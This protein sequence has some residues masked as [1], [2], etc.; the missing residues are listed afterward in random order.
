MSLETRLIAL[1]QAIGADIKT[2]TTNQGIL[3]NLT[4]TTKVN[5][6]AAIN[7]LV[8]E[9]GDLSSLN[10]TA[11][12]NLVAALNEVLLELGDVT[13]L[14]TSTKV[15][16]VA[17]INEL[18]LAVDALASSGAGSYTNVTPTPTAL[19]GIASGST[20]SAVTW[21]GMFDSLLYPY[22]SPTFSSFAFTGQSTPLE[23]GDSVASNRTFTWATTN[24]ANVTVNSV[25][26]ETP[27]GTPVATG[28]ANDGTEAVT[29]G[30]ITLNTPGTRVFRVK[31]TN[32]N[33]VVFT[34]DN[35]I[36]WRWKRFS[37]NSSTIG[38]LVEAEVEALST[39]ALV[40]SGAA[41]YTFA[42]AAGTYKYIAYP[43]SF[44]TLAI[45]KDQSTNLDVP[46]QALYVVSLTNAFGQ[47]TN[48]NV[49]R[50]TNQLGAAINIVAS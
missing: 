28:L 36:E 35:T 44:A 21:Q 24:S 48:Y 4:T 10:T 6:V 14:T 41:T 34:R 3:A 45:F 38:P 31:A 9:T 46:F 29:L 8:T 50:T 13:A 20:F 15:S 32:T 16:A 37:G 17:A 26:I 39:V 25:S 40:T 30:A 18:K 19:G 47:T 5:L 22:Q 23:V 49:H 1:A 11:K 43:S 27:V 33:S 2:L 7:E 12:S 42:A